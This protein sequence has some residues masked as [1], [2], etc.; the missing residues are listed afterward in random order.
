VKVTVERAENSE[1]VLN[2]ELDWGEVE[3]ASD[4]AY[5]KLAQKYTVPGFRRGHA[6]RSMLE[7]MLGKEAIYQ[8]GLEDLIE[9]SYRQ[10]IRENNLTPLAQ[11]SLDAAPLEMNHP[12]TFTARVPVL[13]PV[14][15]G[16]YQSVR[17]EPPTVEVSD[18]DVDKVLQDLREQQALWL[19]AERPAQVGDHVVADLKMSVGER[20]ISDLHD[21]EFELA[22]SREGIFSGMDQ[23]IVGMSEGETKEFTATI[24]A[25][26]ANDEL[27]GKTAQYSVT[28]K[29]VK[30][31]ELPEVD[32]ELA[33]SSGDY[34]TLDELR[35]GIRRDLE[36]RRRS[37]ARR[38]FRE[39]L[40][41]A[42]TDQ[43]E[44]EIHP[45]LVEDEAGVMMREMQ[46]LLEQNGLS[47]DQF[48]AGSNKSEAD[49]KRD[50]EPE[51]RERVKRDLVL[52][53]IA[54][55]EGIAAS[56]QEIQSFLDMLGSLGGSRPLRLRQLT[57]GQRQNIVNR[58]RR[59]KVI[60]R[61]VAAA[62]GDELEADHDHDHDH[63]HAADEEDASEA[64]ARHAARAGDRE[65]PTAASAEPAASATTATTN[66]KAPGGGEIT[67]VTED[68]GAGPPPPDASA[69]AASS[70]G[71]EPASEGSA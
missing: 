6:P 71:A 45:V 48:L 66:G 58:L 24:P 13:S 37:N 43:A 49:Y 39:A 20:G 25:D 30:Y 16:D 59:D 60:S 11:P 69:G 47:W 32:D 8:E 65:E 22:E 7:R 27:A 3:K 55:A 62:G 2:V 23:H 15:V 44:V 29:G 19:P 17:V 52:D 12:Y 46:R 10:A 40:L 1:A 18:E 28:L 70:A 50:L 34:Q 63:D 21:N 54:D 57:P 33:K 51:A 38:E 35:A 64:A 42:I 36:A 53:A 56:D 5:R 67:A 14:K 61:L 31:R 26:Y 41:K 4:R 68:A 9:D